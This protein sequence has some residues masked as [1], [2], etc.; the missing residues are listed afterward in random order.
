[1][2]GQRRIQGVVWKRG[3]EVCAASLFA[4][5]FREGRRRRWKSTY[6]RSCFLGE[7]HG[8]SII[9]VSIKS[10][11]LL[12]YSEEI[13]LRHEFWSSRCDCIQFHGFANRRKIQ[14][15][16]YFLLFQKRLTFWSSHHASRNLVLQ[17]ALD[18]KHV[19]TVLLF[20][21]EAILMALISTVYKIPWHFT[22]EITKIWDCIQLLNP[23]ACIDE[24][25]RG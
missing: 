25:T 19:N 21:E 12:L 24:L 16:H 17:G 23:F 4:K 20:C 9:L 22:F 7:C 1:M 18:E 6:T 13:I 11:R 5:K 14:L 15:K 3:G 10:L 2:L 8:Y